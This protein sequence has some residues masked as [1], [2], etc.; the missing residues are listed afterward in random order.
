MVVWWL[1]DGCLA[2]C[3]MDGF[4]MV[5]LWL[6]YCRLMVVLWLS[7]GCLMVVLV[8]VCSCSDSPD[9]VVVRDG[10]DASSAVIGQFCRSVSQEQIVSSGEHLY[11]DF[12]V[13][14]RR[15]SQGF[16][17]RATFIPTD[18]LRPDIVTSNA[19][20]PNPASSRMVGGRRLGH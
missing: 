15:Q 4:L 2:G 3:L 18:Q 1:S 11:I 19:I 10:S 16:E 6:C 12:I 8:V 5:V 9:Y 7:D 17:A 20:W 14:G 13:D